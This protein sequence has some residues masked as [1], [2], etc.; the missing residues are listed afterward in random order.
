MARST[1]IQVDAAGRSIRVS[2]PDKVM[3]PETCATKLDVVNH[4]LACGDGV[5]AQVKDRPCTLKRYPNGVSEEPF[6]QKKVAAS[7][8][9]SRQAVMTFPTG[10]VAAMFVPRDL[11]DV[12][13]MAQMGCIDLHPWAVTVADGDHPNEMRIDLDPTDGVAF[14]DVIEVALT[15]RSVLAELGLTGFP[16]TSGSRGIH[17][18]VPLQ[19]EWTFG[20]VRRACLAI[21]RAV[22]DVDERATVEWWKE[23]RRGVFLDY[24]QNARDRT[25]A[26]AYSIRPTGW[27]STPLHWDEV[28]AAAPDRWTLQNFASRLEAVG[29]LTADWFAEPARLDRALALAA[30]HE[31]SGR[32][33]APWPP[34]YP[35]QPGEPLRVQPS[36]RA[37][38]D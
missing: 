4:M 10:R 3:F 38:H 12:V 36:R 27:V 21:G 26:C 14:G 6:Y 11:G 19:P 24:N 31:A 33:D 13:W 8:D 1:A 22:A 35:K 28:P 23:N 30:E 16:K 20:Q 2:S 18:I 15:V 34:H 25:V 32:G 29:D 7:T 37:Q 5:V 9:P 17:I